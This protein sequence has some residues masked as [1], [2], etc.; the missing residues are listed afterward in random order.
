MQIGAALT[1]VLV[2]AGH[3]LAQAALQPTQIMPPTREEVRK[4]MGIPS[5]GDVRGQQDA[6]GFASKP[7]QMAK[8][9]ELSATPPA[10]EK[11]G[12]APLP[13]VAGAICPHDDY[14]YAGR[15]YRQVLPLVTAKTVVLVGVFHKYRRFGAHDVLVFD[16]YKAWR[17]PDG[18]V[19]VAAIREE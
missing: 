4:T 17:T 18:D 8:V 6:V 10:P 15:V 19:P 16:S 12:E 3:L 1:V 5:E 11:L 7:E 13:G 2:S 14:L 9:W